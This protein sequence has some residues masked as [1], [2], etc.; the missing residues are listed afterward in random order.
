MN[1]IRKILPGK[2][3]L[4]CAGTSLC[5][6]MYASADFI[7]DST[8]NLATRNFY[9][10]RD[11]RQD[12]APQSKR[13]EW[14]QGFMLNAQSGYTEG[15]VGFGMDLYAAL[16]IKLDSSDERAGTGLL[17]NSFGD[18]GADEYS[19]ITGAGKMRISKTELKV[20]GGFAPKNPVLLTSDARLLT[21]YWNGATLSSTDIDNL[22]ISAAQFHSTNFRNSSGNHD[23]LLTGNY[24]VASDRFRYVGFDYNFAP[25]VKGSLWRAE[26]EDVYQQNFYGLIVAHK[27]GDW[28]LGANLGYF[29][30]SE[31]GSARAGNIDS[32]VTNVTLSAARGAHSFRVALQDNSGD[33]AFPYVQDADANVAN[34]VQILDFTRAEERSWQVRYD[35]DF[36][37]YGVPGLSFFARYLKGDG[38]EIAGQ[39]GKEWERDL[40]VSYLVQEGPLKNLGVRWRNAMVRSDGAGELDENRLIVSYTIPLK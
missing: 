17:P 2:T 30:S 6:P 22:L 23:E 25:L 32:G 36:T 14:A 3:A 18:E 8:V 13:E 10:S 12:S 38:Y 31:E 21:P 5:L 33:D 28:T 26:L 11:F 4:L 15:T 20:G 27:L 19:D 24:G 35:F 7:E 9:F 1:M 39:S 40:D 37:S 34:V 16:G 29:D